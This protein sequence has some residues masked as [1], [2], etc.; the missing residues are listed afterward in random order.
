MRKSQRLILIAGLALIAITNAIALGGAAYNRS[1]APDSTL[2]L[3]D[4]ELKLPYATWAGNENSGLSLRLSWRVLQEPASGEP[5]Y[6]YFSGGG[7]SPGWLDASKMASLGFGSYASAA[8]ADSREESPYERQLPRDVLLVLELDGSA[9]RQSLE[10]VGRAAAA[11]EA[12]NERGQ[13]KKGADAMIDQETHRNSRLFVVDAG[14]DREALRKKFPDRTRYAIVRGQVR[15]SRMRGAGAGSGVIEGLSVESVN[16][17]LQL[18][19]ALEGA[20]ARG[21]LYGEDNTKRFEATMVWGKRMEPWLVS[22][23]KK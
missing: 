21:Q 1:G 12:R 11:I 6:Q 10:G 2:A 20:R 13:G 9:Y 14:T 4:R 18:R 15:P 19:P 8:Y 22:A 16:V 5:R 7:S 23:A 17:P 3:S